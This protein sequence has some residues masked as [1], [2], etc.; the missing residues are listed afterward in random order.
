MKTIR[1]IL[2]DKNNI[3]TISIEDKINYIEWTLSQ[4]TEE[5]QKELLKMSVKKLVL[6]MVNYFE[7][8]KEVEEEAENE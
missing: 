7:D 3:N 2:D 6:D 4:Y 5:E 8:N 1:I